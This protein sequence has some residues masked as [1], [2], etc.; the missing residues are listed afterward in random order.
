MNSFEIEKV[1]KR[2]HK[3]NRYFL[4]C[5]PANKIPQKPIDVS[6]YPF[7]AVVN[8]DNAGEPGTHWVAIFVPNPSSI[9]YFDSFALP[10]NESINKYLIQFKNLIA[11][12]VV[13]QTIQSTI[14]GRY[15]IYF[16]S[17]RC[18]GNSFRSIEKHL[19]NECKSHPNN[20]VSS[21][22][23]RRFDWDDK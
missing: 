14:C 23:Y 18:R 22:V 11:S 2:D 17:K 16:L 19:S 8:T 1:L 3:V 20:V 13:L 5:F 6:L 15:V 10:P 9:E 4:G 21:F 12:Q 7:C